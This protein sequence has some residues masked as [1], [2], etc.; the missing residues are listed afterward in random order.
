MTSKKTEKAAQDL[1]VLALEGGRILNS[2]T[3]EAVASDPRKTRKLDEI[4]GRATLVL[5]GLTEAELK[6]AL[7]QISDGARDDVFA[8]LTFTDNTDRKS[9]NAERVR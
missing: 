1:E 6:A 3:L 8:L 4:D 2:A 7:D 5:G 9:A